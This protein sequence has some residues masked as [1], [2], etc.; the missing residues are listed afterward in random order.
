MRSYSY[1][2]TAKTIIQSYDGNIPLA[3]WLKQFFKSDKKFGS[4]DRKQIS[5]LCYCFYRLGNAFQNLDAE[6]RMLTAL[7]LCSDNPNKVLEELKPGLNERIS[8]PITEKIN[9][10]LA[11]EEIEQIFAFTTSLSKEIEQQPFNLSFLI[12][13]DLYLRIRPGK[14]KKV[15]QQLQDAEIIF[16]LLGEDCIQLSNQS[17]IDESVNIDEDVIVQDYNSQKTLDLFT[18]F[19]PQTFRMGL[20]C[21]QRRKVYFIS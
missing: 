9:L 21:C 3:T 15:I 17:K 6:E 8:L 10:L 13:P 5:H 14:K 18:N 19:K 7:F 20:L 4:K 2:N 16:T 11:K 12:Q 1:L